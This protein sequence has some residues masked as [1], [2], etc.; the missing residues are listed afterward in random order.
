[1]SRVLIGYDIADNRRRR[2]TCK[3]LRTL[4]ACYQES[5]FDCTI[6]REQTKALWQTLT[7]QLNPN[8]DGL[9]FAWLDATY[10]HALGQRW[11]HGG[12]RLF[13]IS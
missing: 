1:M 8:E 4:T 9:I 5:F 12:D 7:E 2:Q 6:S 10:S 3:R 11:T 13:L